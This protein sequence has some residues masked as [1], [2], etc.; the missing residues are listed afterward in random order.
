ME[1][2]ARFVALAVA[3]GAPPP[4]AGLRQHLVRTFPP[5]TEVDPLDACE[6][7]LARWCLTLED[8]NRNRLGEVDRRLGIGDSGQVL[9]PSRSSRFRKVARACVRRAVE[10]D[11]LGADPWPPAPKGRS[12]RK[13]ARVRRG[14]DVRSLPDP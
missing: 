5:D 3:D 10:L 6:T 7:W 12:R 2:L 9:S 8:L 14:V 11:V 1:A 4:P 13:A